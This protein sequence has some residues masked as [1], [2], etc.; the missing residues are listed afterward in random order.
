[1]VGVTALWCGVAWLIVH[2]LADEWQSRLIAHEREVAAVDATMISAN[3]G[4]KLEHLQYLPMVLARE[5]TLVS[6]L[7]RFGPE[8]AASSLPSNRQREAWLADRELS[9]L[10]RR[11]NSL[12]PEVM[13]SQFLVLNAAGDCIASGGF[14]SNAE[15]ATGVNY[16]DREYYLA[17]RTGHNG[18]QFAV[19]RTTNVPGLFYSSPVFADGRFLG[20][21][22]IKMDLANPSSLVGGVDAFVTDENGVIILAR[23]PHLIMRAVPGAKIAELSPLDRQRRYRVGN[24]APV[25]MD[26]VDLAGQQ[27]VIRWESEPNPFV[28]VEQARPGDILTIHVLRSLREFEAIR[29]DRTSLF[30]LLSLTGMLLVLLAGGSIIYLHRSASHRREMT[31][32]NQTLAEANQSLQELTLTDPLTGLRNRRFLTACMPE[33]IATVERSHRTVAATD[34]VDGLKQNVDL[35]FLMVDLDHFK[36]VN[37][38]YGHLAGDQVLQQVGEI[39]CRAARSTD[40]VARVGG[41]E[42]LVVARQA[43]GTD[44]QVMAERI[45]SAVEAHPFHIG[46]KEIIHC[47]CS[48][49]FSVYPL[50]CDEISY[51]TWEQVV[52]IA[53]QCLYAV[54]HSGRNGW[55]GIVPDQESLR[56]KGQPLPVDISALVRAGILPTISSLN[57]P[58]KWDAEEALK[59]GEQ[60]KVGNEASMGGT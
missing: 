58:V 6:A 45:R 41:E 16:A 12:V 32:L 39:L 52:E 22:V 5:P 37:D 38:H 18:R 53:D 28:L 50:L 40:T 34:A 8:V 4:T 25:R 11:L 17:G 27:A 59:T 3:I 15:D 56:L 29:H 36:K 51:F 35:L 26:R 24:F 23:D 31:R 46:E 9:A 33:D 48:V 30:L 1:V 13:A 21:V 44:S 42:F 60:P 20:V 49:G 7:G 54:K 43:T 2:R 10:A 14:A 19:G 47:T 57:Q 55:V